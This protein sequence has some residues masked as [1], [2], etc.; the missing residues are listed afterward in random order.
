[1]ICNICGQPGHNQNQCNITSDK[2]C[3]NCKQPD[4]DIRTCPHQVNFS[5]QPRF[6]ILCSH[7][8]H[9]GH[10]QKFCPKKFTFP[11]Q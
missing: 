11:K 6:N 10:D 7:C 4:H 9:P 5:V 2:F 1:M 8:K 3:I